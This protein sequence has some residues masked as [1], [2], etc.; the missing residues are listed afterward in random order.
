MKKILIRLLLILMVCGLGYSAYAEKERRLLTE[1][2][3][4]ASG[5]AEK[6]LAGEFSNASKSFSGKDGRLAVI[7]A[8][9]G[10]TVKLETQ[11]VG[12][13][14]K[15]ITAVVGL[16]TSQKGP[17]IKYRPGEPIGYI[18]EN[19]PSRI[20][21]PGIGE[22]LRKGRPVIGYIPEQPPKRIGDI[23]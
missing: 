21:K 3:I 9:T 19:P 22:N 7:G 5:K 1:T 17:E 10:T 18:P 8:T 2:L 6:S 13:L 20:G 12:V 16:T 4:G 15:V 23:R 14:N 11:K